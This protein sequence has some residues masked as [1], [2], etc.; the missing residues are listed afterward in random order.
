MCLPHPNVLGISLGVPSAVFFVT[1]VLV[2]IYIR[3]QLYLKQGDS[4]ASGVFG[5]VFYVLYCGEKYI[6]KITIKP[7]SSSPKNTKPKKDEEVQLITKEE[8]KDREQPNNIL[9]GCM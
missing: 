9:E 3:R 6:A 5:M 1:L 7:P 4:F 2:L 8:N